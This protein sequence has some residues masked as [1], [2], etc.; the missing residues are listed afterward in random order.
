MIN[1]ICVINNDDMI[2]NIKRQHERFYMNNEDFRLLKMDLRSAAK[3]INKANQAIQFF[4]GHG[5]TEAM[6]AIF[7]HI[8][9][10]KAELDS[11]VK[12]HGT[13]LEG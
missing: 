3:I 8:R 1:Y 2:D 9:E 11:F 12:T 6:T 5:D 7:N 10:V 4:G 13:S